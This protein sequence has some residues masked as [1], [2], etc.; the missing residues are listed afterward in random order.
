MASF[1]LTRPIHAACTKASSSSS[2]RRVIYRGLAS[3]AY[4]PS[5]NAQAGPSNSG[6]PSS[7]VPI[8][9]TTTSPT[10][11]TDDQKRLI[12]SIIRVDQAGELGANWIYRGQKWAMDL[13]GDKETSKQVEEMWDNERHHL[14]ILSHLQTQHRARPTM[15]YPLW[16]AMAF[17][18][19]AGT[20]LMS[21]EAA[22]ACTEAV[23]TVIGEHYDDQLKALQPLLQSESPHPS[24]PL[25]ADILKEFR[26]DELE[27][28]DTAV[29]EG[30][31][32][33]PGHSLLSAIIGAG[34]KVAIKVCE[35]V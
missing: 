30:A 24:I 19:G 21:K 33:A 32:K 25:M 2:T 31:Q 17:G 6:R 28:L 27:H 4:L 23:E 7:D 18:L 20:G 10:N 11:L 26:D 15:L 1:S 12:D 3:H 14:T 35:K 34:C 29:E 5:S 9:A 8:E 13:K 16:Q 22:M